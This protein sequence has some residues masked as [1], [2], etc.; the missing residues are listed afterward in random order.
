MDWCV[1]ATLTAVAVLLVMAAARRGGRRFGGMVAALPLVTAPALAWI[2]HED[3]VAFAVEAAIG[4]TA[5]CAMMALFALGYAWAAR[6]HRATVALLCGLGGA[7]L[8]AAPAL[9]A[10]GHAAD[11]LL[12]ACTTCALV[13]LRMPAGGEDVAPRHRSTR[14]MV[15]VALAAAGI[16]AL[17]A[18]VGP[19]VGGFAAGLLASLPVITASVAMFEHT[20]CGHR[21]A[22]HF[23]RGYVGGLVGKAAFGVVFAW[24]APHTGAGVALALACLC[25]AVMATWRARPPALG[26]G[27]VAP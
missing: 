9:M 22:S 24:L 16:A 13:W 7:A 12:L 27:G 15:F 2:V 4:S 11:A 19:S 8:M 17:A 25:V 26:P 1:K 6:R 20:A 23:L 3:G 21:A 18:S 5:A 10:S 14:S